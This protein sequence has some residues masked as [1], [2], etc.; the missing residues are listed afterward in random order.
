MSGSFA[1]DAAHGRRVG[2]LGTDKAYPKIPWPP[3]C[4]ALLVSHSA[5][6]A[7]T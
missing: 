4:S 7:S 2:S 6:V 5:Q 3:G 1:R